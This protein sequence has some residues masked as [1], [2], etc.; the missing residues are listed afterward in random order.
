MDRHNWNITW[1]IINSRFLDMFS[2]AHFLHEDMFSTVVLLQVR[3]PSSNSWS[4]SR[5]DSPGQLDRV[6]VDL[7]LLHTHMIVGQLLQSGHL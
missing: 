4:K 1:Q 6:I 5:V 2:T 7:P 3:L